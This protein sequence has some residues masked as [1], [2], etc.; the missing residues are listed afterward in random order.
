M[1]WGQ[2]SPSVV[3]TRS[4]CDAGFM[5]LLETIENIDDVEI[6][7]L[8]LPLDRATISWLSRM[9]RNDIEAAELIASILR[10]VVIDDERAH[11]T[12]H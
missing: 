11:S 8:A 5:A 1:I 12:M 3:P 10:E 7:P 2:S 4:M 6:V 9:S